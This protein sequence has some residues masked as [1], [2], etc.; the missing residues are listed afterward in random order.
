M[1]EPDGRGLIMMEGGY[2]GG[3]GNGLREL[4]VYVCW[5]GYLEEGGDRMLSYHGGRKDCIW[6]K[7]NMPVVLEER[8]VEEVMGKGLKGWEMWYSMKYD[9][10][11]VLLLGKDVDVKS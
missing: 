3:G 7:E 10:R 9:R 1:G 8:L 6:I 5:G 4:S 11:E 2:A